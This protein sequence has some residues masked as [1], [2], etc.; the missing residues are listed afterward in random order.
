MEQIRIPRTDEPGGHPTW[1]TV[2]TADPI[3]LNRVFNGKDQY[4]Q[5]LILQCCIEEVI[6]DDKC[7]PPSI[8][9]ES[10][11]GDTIVAKNMIW[12]SPLNLLSCTLYLSH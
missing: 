3:V 6:E 9:F 5:N 8:E 11:E 4:Y 2:V 7:P 12:G 10:D 1:E